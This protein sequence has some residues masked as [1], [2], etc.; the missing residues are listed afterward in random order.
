MTKKSLQK[1]G[2]SIL[3]K[4]NGGLQRTEEGKK[5]TKRVK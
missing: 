4:G 2:M 1:E 3:E 5:Q